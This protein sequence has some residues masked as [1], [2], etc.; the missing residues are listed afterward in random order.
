[1]CAMKTD[2]NWIKINQIH[3]NTWKYG[4]TE[5][6]F[7]KK[8]EGGLLIAHAV[9]SYVTPGPKAQLQSRRSIAMFAPETNGS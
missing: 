1:M 8:P 6:K 3:S 4:A 9:C 5:L 7:D 2:E